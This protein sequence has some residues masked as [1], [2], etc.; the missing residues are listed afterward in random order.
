MAV[1]KLKMF[2]FTLLGF[3]E[4]VYF[5]KTCTSEETMIFKE[6]QKIHLKCDFVD[7]SIVNGNR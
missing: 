3:T 5:K 4:N 2:F 1:I 6:I 7:G